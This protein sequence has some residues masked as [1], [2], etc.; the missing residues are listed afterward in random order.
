MPR[1]QHKSPW[2]YRQRTYGYDMTNSA[3]EP[4]FTRTDETQ[5]RRYGTCE[6]TNTLTR[7]PSSIIIN[8]RSG[9]LERQRSRTGGSCS[10]GHIVV[11]QLY[12]ARTGNKFLR[13]SPL[14][15]RFAQDFDM[16]GNRAGL[17]HEHDDVGQGEW[18]C[19]VS[20]KHEKKTPCATF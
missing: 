7:F 3:R 1:L 16:H 10:H 13:P 15:E 8:R 4:N 2:P 5:S 17:G 18:T 14:L 19:R 6:F 11:R 20:W 9:A 12:R